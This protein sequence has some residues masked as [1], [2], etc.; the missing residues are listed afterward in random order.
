MAPLVAKEVLWVR[1]SAGRF[2][3]AGREES[4]FRA[5]YYPLQ[6]S[7]KM[8]IAKEL[9]KQPVWASSSAIVALPARADWLAAHNPDSFSE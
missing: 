7:V 3:P 2:L 5:R 9:Y 4:S 8:P 6:V 1:K